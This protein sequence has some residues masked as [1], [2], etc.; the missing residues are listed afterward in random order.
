[1]DKYIYIFFFFHLKSGEKIAINKSIPIGVIP[2]E[3]IF[4]LQSFALTL[5]ILE[6]K[7]KIEDYW[8][9]E[10]NYLI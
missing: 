7:L 8:R 9:G 1:M 4:Q 10:G 2:R 6:D 5:K 3:N